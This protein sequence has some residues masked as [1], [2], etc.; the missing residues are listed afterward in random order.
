[1]DLWVDNGETSLK[2]FHCDKIVE[3]TSVTSVIISTYC[4]ITPLTSRLK[5]L[6]IQT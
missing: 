3:S 6:N 4:K 5:T 1:M 2:Q